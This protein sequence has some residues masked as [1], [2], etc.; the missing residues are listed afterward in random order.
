MNKGRRERGSNN[1]DAPQRKAPPKENSHTSPSSSFD[2]AMRSLCQAEHSAAQWSRVYQ[3]RALKVNAPTETNGEWKKAATT[4]PSHAA[5][6]HCKA[7]CPQRPE[8]AAIHG[9]HCYSIR[10]SPNSEVTLA[11]SGTCWRSQPTESIQ[12][13]R[14]D[15]TL[16][17]PSALVTAEVD[18]QTR[19]GSRGPWPKQNQKTCIE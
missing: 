4:A 11:C 19:V 3:D 6:R 9:N 13:E 16:Q 17:S 15:R 18:P 10:R 8:R 14:S 12:H 1:N 7:S 5:I 2:C